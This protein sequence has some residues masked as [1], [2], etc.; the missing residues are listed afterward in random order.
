MNTRELSKIL[1]GHKHLKYIFA[2]VFPADM[3]PSNPRKKKPCA[4]IANTHMHNQPGEH[5]ICFYFPAIGYPEY[6]DSYGLAPQEEFETF[7]NKSYLYSTAFVQF[8]LSSACGQYCLYFILQRSKGYSM[9]NI[10]SS[11]STNKLENDAMVNSIVEDSFCVDLDVF[12][13]TYIAK[14]IAHS[15]IEE[16]L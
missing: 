16:P 10:I 3:L 2:G 5:W 9:A 12:D 7:L 1:R 11:F 14:Q 6:F 8:P 4:Y 15:F 13:S